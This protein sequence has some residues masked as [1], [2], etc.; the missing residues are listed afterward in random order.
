MKY[1]DTIKK[2]LVGLIVIIALA[3]AVT[4]V[5]FLFIKPET[6]VT[7]KSEV[8]KSKILKAPI[9]KNVLP[10]LLPDNLPLEKDATITQNFSAKSKDGSIQATRAYETSKTLA[11]N[12]QLFTKYLKDN[13]WTIK[14]TLDNLNYKKVSGAKGNTT[15]Q[16]SISENSVSKIKTVTISMV[17][18]P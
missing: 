4:M 13:G 12:L 18:L 16:I 14:S 7:E 1:E 5:V 15:I 6:Q 3:L 11:E 2:Y 10:E 17:Q 8:T 9:S